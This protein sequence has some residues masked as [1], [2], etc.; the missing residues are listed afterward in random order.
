MAKTLFIFGTR[1]EAIKLAP[2]ILHF[3]ETGLDTRVCV[4]AQHR[5]L[6][7]QVLEIFRIVPDYDLNVMTPG[8]SL[9]QTTS[10]VMAALDPILQAENPNVV[11]VQGDTTS[12]FCGAL[13]AFYRRIPVAHIEA[14]LRTGDPYQPFPEEINRLL[15]TRLATLHF[16]PTQ[17]SAENLFREGIDPNRVTVTGNTGIDAV[18]WVAQRLEAGALVSDFTH[19]DSSRKLILVTAHRRESFGQGM[20]DLC[21]GLLGIA[22]RQDV[23]L[24]FPVHPNPNVREPVNRL[25]GGHPNIMLVD[26]QP[27]VNFVDLMRRSYLLLTDSGGVQEE[28]PSLGKPVLVMRNVTERPEGVYA[29][30]LKLVGTA[31]HQITASVNQLLDDADLYRR[32]SAVHNVYGDGQAAGRIAELIRSFFDK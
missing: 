32:M 14:G 12:T 10:R 17:A 2:V 24:V 25:L 20:E 3:R 13:A 18:L 6:L 4:T 30:A 9:A 8:Q 29:G 23:Q 16:P 1:P 22:A 31:A 5:G 15:T 11:L 27:Y 28:G 19:L 21:R 26:P 7:D